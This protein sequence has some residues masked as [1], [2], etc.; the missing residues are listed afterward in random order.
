MKDTTRQ[1]ALDSLREATGCT[2]DEA[3]STL[4][5]TG[6]DVNEAVVRIIESESCTHSFLSS[7]VQGHT[8]VCE[9]VLPIALSLRRSLHNL[10]EQEA[11]EES[12]TFSYVQSFWLGCCVATLVS[13]L[14]LPHRRR[15]RSA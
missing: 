4:K 12:G 9:K 11:K 10:S 2:L 1:R 15:M 13:L 14:A 8:I 3:E 7:E 6:W 5:E